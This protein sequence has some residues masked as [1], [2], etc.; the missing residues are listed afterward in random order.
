[1]GKRKST[2]FQCQPMSLLI[3]AALVALTPGLANALIIVPNGQT[4]SGNGT[5]NDD[6]DV[7]TG[8][9]V[10][11]GTPVTIDT[12]TINGQLDLDGTLTIKLTGAGAG[13]SDVIDVLNSFDI[14]AATLDFDVLSALDDTA[15]IFASYGT[16][17]GGAFNSI[18]TLPS[19]YS[20][21]YNYLSGSQIALVRDSG[22]GSAPEPATLA[23]MGI[24]IAGIGYQRRRKAA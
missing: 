23:L 10:A 21:D 22:T 3:A 16:L 4:L 20:I 5:V 9:T 15:H 19:N 1:M 12:L 7:L 2:R 18:L 13:D 6:V 24:G 14:T 17:V 11:P 8:G